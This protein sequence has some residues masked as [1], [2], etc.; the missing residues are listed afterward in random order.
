MGTYEKDIAS[1][2]P[3]SL[4]SSRLKLSIGGNDVGTN[5]GRC[6]VGVGEE[7]FT[8]SLFGSVPFDVDGV[9][10]MEEDELKL[11]SDQL[12]TS[13]TSTSVGLPLLPPIPILPPPEEGAVGDDVGEDVN[14]NVRSTLSPSSKPSPS[15]IGTVPLFPSPLSLAP[16]G[17]TFLLLST[18][19]SLLGNNIPKKYNTST[20]IPP[21]SNN[22]NKNI[23]HFLRLDDFGPHKQL[24]NPSQ[25]P[26]RRRRCTPVSSKN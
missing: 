2:P 18:F 23:V 20:V 8:P 4:S 10:T 19:S 3:I 22:S 15:S 21:S 26:H 7:A 12:N 17:T 13:S 16:P 1:N 9:G 25:H 6:T 24:Q 5:D 11:S 14:L